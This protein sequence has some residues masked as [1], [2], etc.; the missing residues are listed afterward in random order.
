MRSIFLV[1]VARDLALQLLDLEPGHTRLLANNSYPNSIQYCI[2]KVIKYANWLIFV[3]G[4]RLE[5]PEVYQFESGLMDIRSGSPTK[6]FGV[7]HIG[8]QALLGLQFRRPVLANRSMWE[9]GRKYVNSMGAL[10]NSLLRRRMMFSI[11]L[12]SSKMI[13]GL[14]TA[15]N[16]SCAIGVL[17]FWVVME[18]TELENSPDASIMGTRLGISPVT[19]LAD[20]SL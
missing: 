3:H 11:S 14:R 8:P 6:A 2:L 12:A 15:G 18:K 9:H 20:S 16:S 19:R 4:R 17:S 5:L 1:P 10:S 13:S 7:R